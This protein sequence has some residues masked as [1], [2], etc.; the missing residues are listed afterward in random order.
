MA[1]YDLEEARAKRALRTL[2]LG[3]EGWLAP[4]LG[5]FVL[6][7]QPYISQTMTLAM[8]KRPG[9]RYVGKALGLSNYMP[10]F[11]RLLDAVDE[12]TS[13]VTQWGPPTYH[14]FTARDYIHL[15]DK[16]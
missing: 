13:S 6:P 5:I 3:E 7:P 8:V 11:N 15:V 16:D 1:V 12:I 10:E 2:D 4:N 14:N 9:G